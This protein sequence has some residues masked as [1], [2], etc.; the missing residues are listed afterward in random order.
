MESHPPAINEAAPSPGRKLFL[1]GL[2]DGAKTTSEDKMKL[3]QSMDPVL[4]SA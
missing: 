2:R 3:G 1:S 4:I